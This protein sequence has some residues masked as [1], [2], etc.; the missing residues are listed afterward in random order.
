MEDATTTSLAQL[1]VEELVARLAT[2][3]PVPGGGSAAAIA[4][5]MGAALVGMVVEL[6]AGRPAAEEHAATLADLAASSARHRAELLEMAQRDATA[7]RSVV[8]ARRLPRETDDQK[9]ERRRAVGEAMHAAAEAPLIVARLAVE[10]MDD[11]ARVAPIGNVNAVSDAG[12]AALLAATAVRGA[13]LNV[14][15]NL[16]Y[17][18]DGDPLRIGTA[19]ELAGL[20][21][22]SD[23]LQRSA[24]K[25]VEERMQPT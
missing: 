5:A 23:E 12:V 1:S 17:L 11:A 7:Y 2:S 22:R 21:A 9:A 10:V 20:Q 15:I 25:A 24:L 6:T 14:Q 16:P 19:D 18:A 4:G 3:D 8:A 13:I